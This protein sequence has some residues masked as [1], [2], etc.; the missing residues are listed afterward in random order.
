MLLPRE[1]SFLSLCT[2]LRELM[3]VAKKIVD[4]REGGMVFEGRG[5]CVTHERMTST[6]SEDG[7]RK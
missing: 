1:C 3:G 7:D 4:K 5:N 2:A 6:G